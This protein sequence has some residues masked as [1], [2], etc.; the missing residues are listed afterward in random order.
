LQQTISDLLDNFCTKN[1][2]K[3]H[4]EYAALQRAIIMFIKICDDGWGHKRIDADGIHFM[5]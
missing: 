2:S 4:E 3:T 5:H 1:S